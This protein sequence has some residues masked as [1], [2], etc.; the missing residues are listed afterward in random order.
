LSFAALF[1]ASTTYSN[2]RVSLPEPDTY[3]AAL[4]AG[5]VVPSASDGPDAVIA[6]GALLL[7]AVAV[8][9]GPAAVVVP[10]T[11]YVPTPPYVPSPKAVIV[12]FAGIL[13]V[14]AVDPAV[15]PTLKL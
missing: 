2:R 14:T 1:P 15:D 10:E 13:A 6:A 11:L 9:V 4:D 5:D 3:V 12:V 8:I 7:P